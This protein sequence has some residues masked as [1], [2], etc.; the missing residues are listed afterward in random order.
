VIQITTESITSNVHPDMFSG[1]VCNI[2]GPDNVTTGTKAYT[3]ISHSN[4]AV[5]M[6]IDVKVVQYIGI[7]CR[8]GSVCHMDMF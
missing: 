2:V 8:H 7:L 6:Q 4:R 3:W 5:P 1:A